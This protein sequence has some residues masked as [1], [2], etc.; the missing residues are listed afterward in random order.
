MNYSFSDNNSFD[1]QL[2]K[3]NCDLFSLRNNYIT[4]AK[5]IIQVFVD[6]RYACDLAM[7]VNQNGHFELQ[8][9]ICVCMNKEDNEL[10][11]ITDSEVAIPFSEVLTDALDMIVNL[12]V[13]DVQAEL[14]YRKLSS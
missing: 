2:N 8:N 10:Y 9:I 3:I 13:I 6:C 12:M 14:I 4:L 7:P 11:L 1:M 5:E